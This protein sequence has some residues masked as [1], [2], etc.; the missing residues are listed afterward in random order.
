MVELRQIMGHKFFLIETISAWE[1]KIFFPYKVEG[2]NIL[3]D[4]NN[5]IY[6]ASVF[7]SF[8]F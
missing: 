1:T 7:L 2:G 8:F 3:S 6:L 5:N 4:R